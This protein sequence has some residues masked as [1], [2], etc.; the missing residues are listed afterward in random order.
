MNTKIVKLKGKDKSLEINGVR[1]YLLTD[2]LLY[3]SLT[4]INAVILF[5]FKNQ[6]NKPVYYQRYCDYIDSEVIDR[7]DLMEAVRPYTISL[8]LYPEAFALAHR[9]H[10]LNNITLT[11]PEILH[12]A[13]LIGFIS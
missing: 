5:A 3:T 8:G 4:N 10:L 13:K 7:L 2:D 11:E 12:L 9:K 6:P 1:L